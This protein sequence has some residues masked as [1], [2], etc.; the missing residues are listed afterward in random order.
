MRVES[1]R[2]E[3]REHSLAPP[4]CVTR[5]ACRIPRF[6]LLTRYSQRALLTRL[7]RPLGT[8]C[9]PE[10]SNRRNYF[11]LMIGCCCGHCCTPSHCF[12]CVWLPT[13]TRLPCPPANDRAKPI[14]SP[15]RAALGR[16]PRRPFPLDWTFLF[17]KAVLELETVPVHFGTSR[18]SPR[19]PLIMAAC[20]H[21]FGGNPIPEVI[22]LSL[23][24]HLPLGSTANSQTCTRNY[25][26]HPALSLSDRLRSLACSGRGRNLHPSP[27]YP[28][29]PGAQ[30]FGARSLAVSSWHS[31]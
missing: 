31:S 2:V 28:L 13:W 6:A 19:R 30:P 12:L 20:L 17:D 9:L 21:R 26:G 11:S 10:L 14:D 27:P 5:S 8:I 18:Q 16:R 3:K 22:S 23:S 24:P 29:S 7:S 15:G 1:S 4:R 25:Q